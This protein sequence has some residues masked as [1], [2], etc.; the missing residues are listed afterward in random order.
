MDGYEVVQWPEIQLLMDEPWFNECI[1]I[2]DDMGVETYGSSAYYVP[3]ERL[4]LIKIK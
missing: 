2:N 1:L 3:T 4:N